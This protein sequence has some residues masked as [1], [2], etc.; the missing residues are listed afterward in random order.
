MNT[1]ELNMFDATVTNPTNND[2]TSKRAN[3]ALGKAWNKWDKYIEQ[4]VQ[5]GKELKNLQPKNIVDG[6]TN[7]DLKILQ[8]NI[9]NLMGYVIETKNITNQKA[10]ETRDGEPVHERLTELLKQHGK[11]RNAL[12]N[13]EFVIQN[14]YATDGDASSKVTIEPIDKKKM[15]EYSK[16]ITKLKSV[17]KA[18]N[19]KIANYEENTDKVFNK[20]NGSDKDIA[21]KLVT[22][23]NEKIESIFDDVK[24]RIEE[25][26]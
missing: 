10:I 6:L 14:T 16:S 22:G 13:Q 20:L 2:S 12:A 25:C 11:D 23:S 7:N 8:Q 21:N 1:G 9:E 3:E 24:K 17:I 5:L 26:S 19:D 15:D 4:V 18:I